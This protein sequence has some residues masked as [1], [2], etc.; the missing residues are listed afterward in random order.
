MKIRLFLFQIAQVHKG[1]RFEE[2]MKEEKEER[3]RME[4]EQR[5]RTQA[6]KDRAKIFSS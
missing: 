5:E 1:S 6:F 4:Q 2:E 3:I